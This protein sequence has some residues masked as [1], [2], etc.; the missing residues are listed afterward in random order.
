ML[1]GNSL[2]ESGTSLSYG[3]DHFDN[4][5]LDM[6]LGDTINVSVPLPTPL[7][8]HSHLPPSMKTMKNHRMKG[9][10]PSSHATVEAT[11]KRE[12]VPVSSSNAASAVTSTKK[13]GGKG[14][15]GVT[16]SAASFKKE[17]RPALHAPRHRVGRPV[18]ATA[19]AVNTKSTVA[20]TLQKAD[21]QK[22]GKEKVALAEIIPDTQLGDEISSLSQRI[23]A[24]LGY[25]EEEY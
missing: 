24:R 15:K 14:R 12:G 22:Q 1:A 13:K 5:A 2:S 18:S 4:S 6:I 19:N 3:L 25:V 21:A 17:V 11:T 9:V 8:P 20:K 10:A 7:Q 23:R 16:E